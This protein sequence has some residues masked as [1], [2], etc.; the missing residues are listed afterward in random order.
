MVSAQHREIVDCF[1]MLK[2]I[3]FLKHTQG[4][5]AENQRCLNIAD[6]EVNKR[7]FLVN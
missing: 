7:Q 2:T 6:F 4:V 5:T 3:K 1:N